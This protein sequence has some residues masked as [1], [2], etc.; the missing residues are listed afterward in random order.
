MGIE[1][2]NPIILGASNL[3]TNID[4]LKKAEDQGVGAI[5][6]RSLF[7][8]QIQLESFQLEEQ[9]HRVQ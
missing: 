9:A 8:E 7:E 4:N 5:V 2:N 3:V 6:Y 1:L